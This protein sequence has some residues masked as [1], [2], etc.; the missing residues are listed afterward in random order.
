[1]ALLL[2]AGA[3]VNA[4]DEFST[5]FRTAQKKHMRSFDGK[6]AQVTPKNFLRV[7]LRFCEYLS[8]NATE[9]R[10]VFMV[11]LLLKNTTQ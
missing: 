6:R 11:S 4:R 5:A 1:M 8:V 3:D 7:F 2:K 9:W 10:E